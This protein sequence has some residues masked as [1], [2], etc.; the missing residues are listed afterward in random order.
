MTKAKEMDLKN[1][2]SISMSKFSNT[3]NKQII[4]SGK[5]KKLIQ[6]LVILK[7]TQKQ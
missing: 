1:Q 2:K 4:M 6:P 5:T 7:M 3:T